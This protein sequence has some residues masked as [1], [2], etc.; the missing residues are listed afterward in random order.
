MGAGLR[1]A[2]ERFDV[3]ALPTV[4][5]G[6]L[7][8][9]G[10]VLALDLVLYLGKLARVRGAAMEDFG[11]PT[12][13]NLVAPAFM[14]AMVLGAQLSAVSE[15]GRW[16]WIAAA[17]GHAFL[18][19]RFVGRWLTH[20]YDP[21]DLNPTWFLPSAGI[22]TGSMT[23]RAFWP[24]P[25]TWILFAAGFGLW[26]TLL[27]LVVRRLVVEPAIAPRLRPT[28]FIIAAPAGLAANSILNLAP[29]APWQ[30]AAMLGYFGAFMIA[31]LLLQPRFILGAGVSLSWWATTFPTATVAA[32][33][34]NLSDR[35]GSAIDAALGAVVLTLAAGFTLIALAAA[36]R[37]GWETGRM[38][39][40]IAAMCGGDAACEEEL[41]RG[42]A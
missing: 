38:E 28:L 9:A 39:A 29:E 5:A 21:A 41:R 14:A 26:L 32:A 23:A 24:E 20:D 3:A 18:L 33:L 13:A 31:A 1:L 7:A 22:M 6:V 16:L 12:S 19:L 36:L 30:I 25:L 4:G 42:E 8:A 35:T 10:V 27:P 40:E 15:L 17:S 2:A 34:L 11:N 37:L